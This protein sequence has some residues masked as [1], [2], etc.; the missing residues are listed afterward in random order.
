M[1]STKACKQ[2]GTIYEG[3]KCPKCGSEDHSTSFKGKIIIL[4]PDESEIAKH[5]KRKEKGVFAIRP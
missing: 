4:N 2:C 5:I 3:S 1:A